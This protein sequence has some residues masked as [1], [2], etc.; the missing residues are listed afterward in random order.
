MKAGPRATLELRASSTSFDVSSDG[1]RVTFDTGIVA[2]EGD[3]VGIF[4]L[5][6]ED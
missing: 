3:K 6:G 5:E 1:T 4:W 2:I